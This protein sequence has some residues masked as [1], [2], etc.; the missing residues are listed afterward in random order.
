MREISLIENL[1]IENFL[2]ML[3]PEAREHVSNIRV[4]KQNGSR[5]KPSTGLIDKSKILDSIKRKALLDK[6]ASLV[7]ENLCGRSEM[8]IQFADLLERALTFLQIPSNAVIGRAK[9]YLNGE[10]VFKWQHAWVQTDSEI[11]DGNLDSTS[12][13]PFIP[14]NLK[15]KPYW[16]PI[17]DTPN[18]RKFEADG[19]ALP[20]EDDVAKI[21]WPELQTWIKENFQP[22]N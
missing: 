5:P 18:D 2:T 16:G 12:E 4:Q 17:T 3:P 9:Y 1:S 14:E 15:L 7:D 8:C 21:W 20:R 6:I 22:S 11:I 19:S 10:E 13:N